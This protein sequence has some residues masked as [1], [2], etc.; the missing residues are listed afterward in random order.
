MS[1][2]RLL[3]AW[4]VPAFEDD[5]PVD[6]TWVTTYDNRSH[7]YPSVAAV[8]A[9][10]ECAWYCW[11]DFHPRGGTPGNPDGAVGA[12]VGNLD[13]ARC[14]A[15][16]NADCAAS[17]AAR[18]TIF[19]YGV[20]GVCHQLANQVLYATGVGGARPLTAAAARGYRLSSAIYGTYGLQSAAWRNKIAACAAA[21]AARP[22]NADDVAHAA[23]PRPGAAM[24]S[25]PPDEFEQRVAEV[26][27]PDRLR[28]AAQLLNLR[29]RFHTAAAAEAH[30]MRAP[31]ADELNERNQRFF[32]DAA[33]ILSASDYERIFGVEPGRKVKLVRPDRTK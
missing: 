3:Y 28:L 20:D 5:F 16:P 32:D 12:Q 8:E 21:M 7:P 19:T 2:M 29:A 13:L 4:A 23:P 24:T 30:A 33:K 9:A 11:G 10:V 22:A 14:F 1:T 17:F 26:L 25:V 6:H 31:T 27:G 18:G 15:Q